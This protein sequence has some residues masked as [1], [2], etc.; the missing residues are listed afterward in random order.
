MNSDIILLG[1]QAHNRS[2]SIKLGRL[3][4]R[5]IGESVLLAFQR[6]GRV[7]LCELGRA[8]VLVVFGGGLGARPPILCNGY[9][10]H[11]ETGGAS[12]AAARNIQRERAAS[13]LEYGQQ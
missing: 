6:Q 9:G 1:F 13:T 8:L 3:F 7:R 5:G 10:S 12:L 4:G 2:E 11:G